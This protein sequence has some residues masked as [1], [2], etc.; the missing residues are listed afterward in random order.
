MN[1]DF[2]KLT[3]KQEFHHFYKINEKHVRFN[4]TRQ[5]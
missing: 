4:D 3:D 1:L 2:M 5:R